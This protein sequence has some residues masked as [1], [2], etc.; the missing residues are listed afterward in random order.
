MLFRDESQAASG[1]VPRWQTR[2]ARLSPPNNVRKSSR[3]PSIG[4]GLDVSHHKG[5]EQFVES[6][7]LSALESDAALC[8]VPA[9]T[10]V[11]EGKVAADS[12]LHAVREA[13]A[14]ALR[15]GRDRSDQSLVHKSRMQYGAAI[16]SLAQ[17][18][19]KLNHTSGNAGLLAIMLMPLAG[20]SMET[21][22]NL[23]WWAAHVRAA[24]ILV[25]QRGRTMGAD[26]GS[27][28]V[29]LTVRS[30]AVRHL[31]SVARALAD[32]TRS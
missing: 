30:L 32:V 27:V 10:A 2:H 8:A 26:K 7:F 11:F 5:A 23:A 29:L 9:I 18:V 28:Q 24:E 1:T 3:S 20:S 17:D 15:A 16:S 12:S 6:G 4:D 13:L 31:S 25:R 21:A 22:P 19:Q 14:F